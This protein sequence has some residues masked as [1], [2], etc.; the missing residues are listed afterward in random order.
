M[1]QITTNP[2]F[3]SNLVHYNP[4]DPMN[5]KVILTNKYTTSLQYTG[6]AVVQIQEN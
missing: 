2:F 4:V 6:Y 1:D 5:L 3:T